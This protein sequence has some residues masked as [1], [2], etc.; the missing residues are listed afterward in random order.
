MSRLLRPAA[1]MA[2]LVVL[3]SLLAA[4][5][6]TAQQW[7]RAAIRRALQATVMILAPDNHGDLYSSGSG[8]VLDADRG[9]ILT[10]YHVMGE[11]EARSLFNDDGIAYIA[12]NPVDL[13]G[14]PVVKYIAR[15]VEGSPEQDLA[16]LRVV[17]LADDPDARLPK[18][19]GLVAVDRGDSE[20]LLP[21][22]PLAVIGF[23]G[24]GGST[25]TFTD[26]V[27][28]GFLD[29]NGDGV[30]EWIKTN[31]EVNP[32]NSGGLAIDT[33]G[34]FIGVPTAGY[35]RAD[36]AGKI[37]LIR[38]GTIALSF[39]D[40]A[41]LGQQGSSTGVKNPDQ[42]SGATGVVPIT[43]DAFG[44]ITFARD[45]SEKDRPVET[46]NTFIGVDTIYA[47]FD[48]DGI[49]EGMPWSTRWLLDGE[50]V[51]REEMTWEGR[52]STTWVSITHPDGLP[53]GSYTLELYAGDNLAQRA[54]LTV[55]AGAGNAAGAA[56]VNVTGIMHDADNVRRTISGAQV[57]VLLPGVTIDA[58]IDAEFD[59][60][61]IHASGVSA[62]GG[63]FRLDNKL[64]PGE[65]YS[66]VVVH[67]DYKPIKV[68]D[69]EVPGDA[70]DPYELDV[71]LERN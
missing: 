70:A 49:A 40:R 3:G 32:G 7:D 28:S 33:A 43:G 45:V 64:T 71:A 13:K 6:A 27:V 34:A 63:V 10:T 20:Q 1:L 61:M 66:V 23:P 58:W 46:G 17:G 53:E 51:L 18:N 62:R 19:L 67:D 41:V 22:D 38:P 8:T 37:S 9:I 59:E 68:D 56:P 69:F 11:P 29:E 39:L 50:E 55:V 31:T 54:S 5:P 15:M 47:F 2:L 12:V 4:S 25:V 60:S 16:V 36:V 35:S 57:V 65:R 42:S 52:A 48:V 26:G 14:S 21:G 30:Y 24:L 44:P